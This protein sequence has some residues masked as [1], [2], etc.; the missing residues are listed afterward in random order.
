MF[1]LS[2]LREVL[3]VLCSVKTRRPELLIVSKF[4]PAEVEVRP[5]GGNE[6]QKKKISAE[7]MPTFVMLWEYV[8]SGLDDGRFSQ[9]QKM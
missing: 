5:K 7:I 3:I 4:F 1:V 2:K 8:M 9:Q 6:I